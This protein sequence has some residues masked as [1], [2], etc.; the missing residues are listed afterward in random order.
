LTVFAG[1]V[2]YGESIAFFHPSAMWFFQNFSVA[3]TGLVKREA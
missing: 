2:S 3:T 1:V